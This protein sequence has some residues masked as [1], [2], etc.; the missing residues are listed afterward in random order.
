[1]SPSAGCCEDCVTNCM[2]CSIEA[3]NV[4][5]AARLQKR[6]GEPPAPRTLLWKNCKRS[7]VSACSSVPFIDPLKSSRKGCFDVGN[8][9][10]HGSRGSS[11]A[12][13][14][15]GQNTGQSQAHC[16]QG[17][18]RQ[19]TDREGPSRQT[20]GGEEQHRPTSNKQ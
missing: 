10:H 4:V 8:L 17:Q 6:A 19:G 3:F 15:A 20:A 14:S 5:Q 16:R 18:A 2:I 7:K 12:P 11:T 13:D 9:S 1:M